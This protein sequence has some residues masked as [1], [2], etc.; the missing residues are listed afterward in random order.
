MENLFKWVNCVIPIRYL[1]YFIKNLQL[2]N[3]MFNVTPHIL[4]FVPHL[5][6]LDQISKQFIYQGSQVVNL[7]RV[8]LTCTGSKLYI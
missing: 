7:G 3:V 2:R 4:L 1:N 5:A 6:K 8:S